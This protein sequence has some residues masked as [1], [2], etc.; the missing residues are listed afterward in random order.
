MKYEHYRDPN[1]LYDNLT[2]DS[3]V[4]YHTSTKE[5]KNKKEIMKL[6]LKTMEM[7]KIIF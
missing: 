5:E 2:D 3:K 7:P 6:F 4:I 1:K